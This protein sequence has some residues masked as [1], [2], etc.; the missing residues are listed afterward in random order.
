MQVLFKRKIYLD[1]GIFFLLRETFVLSN[2]RDISSKVQVSG[3]SFPHS[4]P[5]INKR[6]K[7]RNIL[8]SQLTFSTLTC[9]T[10]YADAGGRKDQLNAH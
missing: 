6:E 9:H 2:H 3:I 7:E 1:C 4:A 10:A 8:E 5:K